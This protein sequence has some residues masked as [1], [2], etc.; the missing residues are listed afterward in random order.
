MIY[1]CYLYLEEILDCSVIVIYAQYIHNII[2][3]MHNEWN[4][5]KIPN[6]EKQILCTLHSD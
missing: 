1:D 6:Q 4:Y 5:L 3:N 2:M